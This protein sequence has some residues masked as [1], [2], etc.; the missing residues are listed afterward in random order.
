MKIL[1]YVLILLI[2]IVIAISSIFLYNPTLIN[3]E[4]KVSIKKQKNSND[5]EVLK[6][7]EDIANNEKKIYT[8]PK[9]KLQPKP[10]VEKNYNAKILYMK[11][12]KLC[13]GNEEAFA[14]K[15]SRYK[16]GEIFENDGKELSDIHERSSVSDFTNKYFKTKEYKLQVQSL[17]KYIISYSK[18]Y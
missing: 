14:N 18:D 4:A 11:Q 13:H 5:D 9:P 15:F 17:S 2:F 3:Y 1:H 6:L 12:C 16:W 8:K 10:I 7:L